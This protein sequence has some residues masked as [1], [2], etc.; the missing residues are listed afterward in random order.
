ME[1]RSLLKPESLYWKASKPIPLQLTK[2]M[3]TALANAGKQKK[4]NEIA[5]ASVQ[6]ENKETGRKQ[7]TLK[8][9]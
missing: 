5:F 9:N 6:L 3:H 1:G 8:I 2:L 7:R 4:N